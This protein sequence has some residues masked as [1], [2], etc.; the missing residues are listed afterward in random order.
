MANVRQNKMYD[1]VFKLFKQSSCV[2]DNILI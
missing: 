2:D 1:I